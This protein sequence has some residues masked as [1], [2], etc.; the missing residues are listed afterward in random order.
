MKSFL[1]Q[2]DVI[3][4]SS[5]NYSLK[6]NSKLNVHIIASELAKRGIKVLFVE[7]LGLK[8]LPLFGSSDISKVGSRLFEFIKLIF[9]G[10]KKVEENIYVLSLIRFPFDDILFFHYLN[11]LIITFFIKHYSKK[12]LDKKPLLW[13]FLPTVSYLAKNIKNSGV[14]YHCVDDYSAVPFV[15]K[16]Y[17]LAS[18]KKMVKVADIIFVISTKKQLTFKDYTNKP[19]IYI[20]NV[21]NFNLFNKALTEDFTIPN[22]LEGIVKKQ[23]PIVGFVGNLAAYKEDL[24]LLI[25]IVKECPEYNFVLIGGV[26]D[27][28]FITNIHPLKRLPNVYMLG[29][30]KYEELYKYMK[31]MKVAI[32]PRRLNAV[33]EGG[34]PMKYFEFLAAGIPTIVTGVGNMAQFTKFSQLG[35][36]ANTPQKFKERIKYWLELETKDPKE[37]KKSVKT[38][39]KIAKQNDWTERI[40]QLNTFISRIIN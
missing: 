11:E 40:T 16:S 37:F 19:I 18:E 33:G 17:V 8:I 38:R 27:G 9:F 10:P 25:K 32:I 13:T 1:A 6:S 7:S 12:Y 22:D 30:K 21:A 15:D 28:D 26:G 24:S 29:P 35:G 39:I 14:I 23:K 5:S 3:L 31:Y 2:K 20:N 4:I 36:V 34:F